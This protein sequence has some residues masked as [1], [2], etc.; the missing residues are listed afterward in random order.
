MGRCTGNSNDCVSNTV[1]SPFSISS[2]L[3]MLLLGTSGKSYEQLRTALG[4]HQETNDSN[5]SEVYRFLM[6]RVKKLDV[7]AGSSILLSVA[8][9]LFSQKQSRFSDN[10]VTQV[11]KLNYAFT[12]NVKNTDLWFIYCMFS[13]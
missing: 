8:N 11:R 3:T 1:F 2:T 6:E 4:Y 7:D 13:G 9:G 5:I 10:Y 12:F